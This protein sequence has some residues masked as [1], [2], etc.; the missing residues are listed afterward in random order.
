M[1]MVLFRFFLAKMREETA[2]LELH[3]RGVTIK[4]IKKGGIPEAFENA[5]IAST[6]GSAKMKATA[7]PAHK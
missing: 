7:A 5:P 2:S 3:A 6:K 1:E 4:E